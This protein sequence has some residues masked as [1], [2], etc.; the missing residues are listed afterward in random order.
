MPLIR[1]FVVLDG[2]AA[3]VFDNLIVLDVEPLLEDFQAPVLR[4]HGYVRVPALQFPAEGMALH[5]FLDIPAG[6]V[7][8]EYFPGAFCPN[9]WQTFRIEQSNLHE[10]AGLIP[11]DV[12]V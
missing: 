2:A 1:P 4:P 5:R 6:K 3:D 10:N 8:I 11:V 7:R 12:F 9:D